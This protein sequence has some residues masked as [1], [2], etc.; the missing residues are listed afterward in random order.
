MTPHLSFAEASALVCRNAGRVEMPEPWLL[1][2]AHALQSL[3]A[4]PLADSTGELAKVWAA[5]AFG[6]RDPDDLLAETLDVLDAAQLRRNDLIKPHAETIR[7]ELPRIVCGAVDIQS[8]E[9]GPETAEALAR[10]LY[11]AER[12]CAAIQA[13]LEGLGPVLPPAVLPP[14][15]YGNLP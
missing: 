11:R 2:A 1:L 8:P 13:L 3:H 10:C 9:A 12:A 5:P 7:R 14:S 15:K 4:E 6:G